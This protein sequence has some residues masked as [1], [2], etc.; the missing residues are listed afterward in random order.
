MND[1]QRLNVEICN[2]TIP[3]Q[4]MIHKYDYRPEDVMRLKHEMA[5]QARVLYG[6]NKMSEETKIIMQEFVKAMNFLNKRH[7]KNVYTGS[8]GFIYDVA[9]NP[10]AL[11]FHYR[12]EAKLVLNI[13]LH[14]KK[15]TKRQWKNVVD[16]FK[17]FNITNIING[18]NGHMTICLFLNIAVPEVLTRPDPILRK[19]HINVDFEKL[20]KTNL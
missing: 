4:E 11:H 10:F 2:D 5:L 8:R 20:V 12:D 3:R 6:E 7:S 18:Q 9:P 15:Y 14:N 16:E 1:M 13:Y 19:R 17:E